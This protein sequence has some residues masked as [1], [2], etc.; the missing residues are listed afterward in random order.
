MDRRPLLARR[1][2]EAIY[3]DLAE[4]DVINEE[5]EVVIDRW[6]EIILGRFKSDSIPFPSDEVRTVETEDEGTVA[7]FLDK[8]PEVRPALEHAKEVALELFPS[9]VFR[10]ALH[11]DPE[12]CHICHEGQ[13]VV[14]EI[15]YEGKRAGKPSVTGSDIDWEAY[16]ELEEPFN[17]R[18]L[19][20]DDCPYRLLGDRSS[21]V[22]INVNPWL[23]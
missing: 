5:P 7:L 18:V 11:S 20:A 12:G 14:M 19:F 17:D 8:Y 9:P 4:I 3:E 6:V 23:P 10:Y 21:L 2:A 13:H 15:H 1:F 22:L 16:R